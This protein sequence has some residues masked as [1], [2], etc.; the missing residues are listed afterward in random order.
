[1]IYYLIVTLFL[2]FEIQKIF[3]FNYFLK[4]KSLS[5]E[6]SKKI[7][8]RTNSIAYKEISKVALVDIFYLL[9]LI[10]GLFTF[11]RYFFCAILLLSLIGSF[12]FRIKNKT[13]KKIFLIVDI[14]ITIILLILAIINFIF[15]KIDSIQFIKQFIC[16]IL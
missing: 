9:T 10:F 4:I 3:Q 5:G 8:R 7:L 14:T 13:I 11:N 16:Q 12:V 1:M 15:Y 6:Y 2:A